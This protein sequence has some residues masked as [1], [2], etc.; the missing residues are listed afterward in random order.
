ME[1]SFFEAAKQG[2]SLAKQI[3]DDYISKLAAGISTF[4]TIFRPQ[5]IILGVSHMQVTCC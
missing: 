1:K 3:V 2:D 4:I 5:V